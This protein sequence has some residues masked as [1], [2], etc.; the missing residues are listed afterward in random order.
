MS[1]NFAR[2]EKDT[3]FHTEKKLDRPQADLQA[4]ILK[5]NKVVVTQFSASA[6]HVWKNCPKLFSYA[7]S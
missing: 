1:V 3:E 6:P 4:Y 2:G 7:S 5:Q